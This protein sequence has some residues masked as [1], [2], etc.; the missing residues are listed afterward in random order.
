MANGFVFVLEKE[1]VLNGGGTYFI[2]VYGQ[3]PTDI[4]ALFDYPN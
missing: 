3:L 1:F 4:G 2:N